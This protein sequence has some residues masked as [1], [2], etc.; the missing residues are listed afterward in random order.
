MRNPDVKW[1]VNR[2]PRFTV[3]EMGEYMAAE[4]GPRETMLRDMRYER[5]ARSLVY[6]HVRRAI[7]SFL[8]SPTRDRVILARCREALEHEKTLAASPQQRENI[9]YELRAL[10]AFEKS[11]N[12]L[13]LAGLNFELTRPA[14]PLVIEGVAISVQPTAHIR[15]RR[16][17][18]TDLVGAVLVDIAKGIEPK[19]PEAQYR[20]TNGMRHAAMLVHQY[21]VRDLAA[22]DAKPSQEHCIVF[23]AHRQERICAPDN[24]RKAL[25]NMEAVCRGVARGWHNITPPPSFDAK[26]ATYR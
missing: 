14:P 16:P 21:T 17:R 23:H 11:L 18:G 10:E 3:L 6:R 25:R 9:T 4:D 15:V 1:R 24:Y 7:S 19:T 22:D 20:L 13:Q 5:L 8:A 26:F 12:A 2:R